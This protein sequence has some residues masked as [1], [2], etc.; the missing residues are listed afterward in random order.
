MILEI[1]IAVLVAA[2]LAVQLLILSRQKSPTDT[3]Q[4]DAILYEQT[5]FEQILRE[6]FAR[7][8][9][10]QQRTSRE[11]REEQSLALRNFEKKTEESF[12]AF[13]EQLRLMGNDTREGLTTSLKSFEERFAQ[14]V[15]EFNELQRQKFNELV[16]KQTEL[17]T[18]TELR[19][20]KVRETV[21]VRLKVM[22]DENAKKLEEMRATVDEKLQTTLEKRLGES[23]KQVSDRLEQVHKGLGEM[24]T[25]ATGVG[26]LKRVLSNVKTRGILGEIQLG[27]ILEQIMAPEQFDRN[28]ATKNGS[29]DVVEFAVKLPGKDVGGKE[30][31]MPIDS[32][33]PL[34][35]Y[36]QLQNAYDSGSAEAVATAIKELERSIKN[37]AKDIRDKYLDPPYTTDF[38]VMFLPIEGLYAEVIRNTSLMEVLQREYRVVITGPTTLAAILNSL[39]MGFRTLAIEKRS[40]EVWQILGAVKTEFSRF[41]DVLKKAQEKIT[42][43]NEDID[44]LVGTRTRA[45]ERKLRNVQE[46]PITQASA[47]LPGVVDEDE[48]EG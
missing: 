31:Y 6:E 12:T 27:N 10:E 19:L 24:Q 20:E 40:S 41:G 5:R 18:T 8:R 7:S 17:N 26:D 2:V 29:R 34:D 39:Q 30:V 16:G 35:V 11:T 15:K 36:N 1:A 43:A 22:Q 42:K 33:F 37:N 13:R 47:I 48:I 32:K 21:E 14:S 46:L 44:Q 23:F 4:L 3:A 38:A 25:L 28:V 45:I 9:E